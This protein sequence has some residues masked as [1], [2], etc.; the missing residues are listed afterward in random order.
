MFILLVISHLLAMVIGGFM[1][2]KLRKV[3]EAGER[4]LY[5]SNTLY[6]KAAQLLSDM[7]NLNVT[8]GSDLPMLPAPIRKRIED[9]L[10]EHKKLH[11]RGR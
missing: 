10:E 3:E 9:W 7:V 8:S 6:L 4:I 11:E 5:S 1:G 2:Y